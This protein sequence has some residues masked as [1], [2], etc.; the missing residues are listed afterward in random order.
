M[1]E[2]CDITRN[3]ELSII[4][5]KCLSLCSKTF[6]RFRSKQKRKVRATQSI[7]LPNGKAP[8]S[9]RQK[10]PQKINRPD[11]DR[12]KGENVRYELT[13][14]PGD[15]DRGKPQELKGQIGP[16]SKLLASACRFVGIIRMGRLLEPVSNGRARSMIEVIPIYRD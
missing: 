8:F 9:R 5:S 15:R 6:Y 12:G 2:F 3:Y 13:A 14:F 11:L 16:E 1:I 4:S 10:V 7:L